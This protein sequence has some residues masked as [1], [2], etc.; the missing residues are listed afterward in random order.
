MRVK[1]TPEGEWVW[2]NPEVEHARLAWEAARGRSAWVSR[3][4]LGA[5][6]LGW[7]AVGFGMPAWVVSAVAGLAIGSSAIAWRR[8]SRAWRAYDALAAAEIDRPVESIVREQEARV[9]DADG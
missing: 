5:T 1:R 3:L 4:G 9:G 6:V 8:M 2:T 7:V